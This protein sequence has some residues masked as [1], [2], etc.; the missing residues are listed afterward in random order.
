MTKRAV[1]FGAGSIGRGF[2]GQLFCESG[3]EVL[4]VDVDAE[5]IAALNRDGAYHLQTVSNDDIRNFRIGPVRA[6]HGVRDT[7]AVVAA[8]A[9]ADL[10]ATAVGVQALK[11]ILPV[12]AAGLR[13]RAETAGAT[14]FNLL[15]CENLKGA[16]AL[17][18][19][20]VRALLPPE[21]QDWLATEV[22]FVDTVI[23]RMVPAPTPEMRAADV[24]F[25]R[26]EPY[27]EL[28][29]D[30]AGFRGPVPAVAAM[31]A[32][33][34]FGI[35][36]ARKLYL[37]NCGH[38]VLGYLGFLRGHVDGVDA[39]NDPAIRRELDGALAESVAGIVAHYGADRAW[40]EAHVADLVIRF[41]NRPLGDPVARLGRDPE[42]KLQPNDRLVGAA[43]LAAEAGVV[44]AH[45]ARGIAAALRFNPPGDPGAAALQQRLQAEGVEPVLADVCR[46]RSDEPLGRLVLNAVHEF[47]ES[48]E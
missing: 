42:R 15:L 16:A 48:H 7:E 27:K 17:V 44:P 6:L 41:A 35:F 5:L 36:T 43:R 31:V 29:V 45:L 10:G 28:P 30:R 25:I 34:N 2:I 14:P 22:G 26:A 11:F 20:Q 8:V 40:L 37:H 32:H 3:Y 18:R 33:D 9:R 12:L 39:L 46:I 38:A 47:H 19:E 13:R 4:F 24:S 21:R 1:I 23:G